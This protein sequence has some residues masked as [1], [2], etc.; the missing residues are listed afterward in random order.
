MADTELVRPGGRG[1]FKRHIY[2]RRPDEGEQRRWIVWA[3]RQDVENMSLRGFEPLWDYGLLPENDPSGE[4]ESNPWRHILTSPGGPEEFPV[5]QVMVLRWYKEEDCPVPGIKFPQLS[6]HKVKEYQCPECNRSPFAA[7]D[8]LG[9]VD[10]LGRHLRLIH[11]WDRASLVKYGEKVGIDFDAI[12]SHVEKTI[13]FSVTAE[14]PKEPEETPEDSIVVGEFE[15]SCGWEPKS[16]AK[17]PATALRMHSRT[18]LEA[19]TA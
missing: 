3:G 1:K 10:P 8:G 19:V 16:N 7:F 11:T 17:R 13:E 5:E 2:Y 9:G 18:H 12:Y 6:G 4:P 14:S 15:C